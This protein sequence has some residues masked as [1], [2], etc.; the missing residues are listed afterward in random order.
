MSNSVIALFAGLH[1]SVLP[2][3]RFSLQLDPLIQNWANSMGGI[4]NYVHGERGVVRSLHVEQSESGTAYRILTLENA[5]FRSVAVDYNSDIRID[6]TLRPGEKVC[7]VRLDAY[8]GAWV[9]LSER[10]EPDLRFAIIEGYRTPDAELIDKAHSVLSAKKR[11][12]QPARVEGSIFLSH[13]SWNKLLARFIRREL[14]ATAKVDVWLD[15]EQRESIGPSGMLD[16][17]LENGVAKA[18][19]VLVLWTAACL[20]SRWV[21]QECEWAIRRHDELPFVILQC[22]QTPV[23]DEFAS[24]AHVV[25]IDRLWYAQGIAEEV[26]S[27]L[28]G[29]EPRSQWV[30]ENER[31][32]HRIKP[33]AADNCLHFDAVDAKEGHAVEDV[34]VQEMDSGTRTCLT[35]CPRGGTDPFTIT[36]PSEFKAGKQSVRVAIDQGIRKGDRVGRFATFRASRYAWSSRWFWHVWMRIDEPHLTAEDVVERS[37]ALSDRTP[38]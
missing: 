38:M 24:Y 3:C 19:G 34:E 22:D 4:I 9:R 21:R 7:F 23:P 30:K 29:F 32:G 35:I 28:H 13:S 37:A 20:D 26:F 1:S 5:P 2:I 33:D 18:R 31:R 10:Y 36:T 16:Q 15:E 27:V 11:N 17:W 8:C 6:P 25:S 14:T 12:D